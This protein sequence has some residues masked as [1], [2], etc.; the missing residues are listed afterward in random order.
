MRDV[1]AIWFQVSASTSKSASSGLD[2]G[3]LLTDDRPVNL[4]ITDK[5]V[6]DPQVAQSARKS[7]V[8]GSAVLLGLLSLVRGRL[9]TFARHRRVVL[10][11][12]WPS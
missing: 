2:L 1:L 6:D 5:R 11:D 7:G 4:L 9:P 12:R 10:A 3:V 8:T